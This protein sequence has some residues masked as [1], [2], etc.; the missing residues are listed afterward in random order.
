MIDKQKTASKSKKITPEQL[1]EHYMIEKELAKKLKNS[2]KKER[3]YLYS[4]LYDELF[5][6]VPFPINP[7]NRFQI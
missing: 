2:S 4:S 3:R 6:K 5:R 1:K 7:K